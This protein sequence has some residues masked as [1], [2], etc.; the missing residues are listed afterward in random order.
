ME[1]PASKIWSQEEKRSWW[2]PISQ[3]PIE[4]ASEDPLEIQISHFCDVI[5]GKTQPRVTGL[6]GLRSLQ[7]VAA[8]KTSAEQKAPVDLPLSPSL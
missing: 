3:R 8:I 7:V 2:E 1:L 4:F 5:S 6:D